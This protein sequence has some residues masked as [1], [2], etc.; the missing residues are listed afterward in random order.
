MQYLALPT[1][2][3]RAEQELNFDWRTRDA[4]LCWYRSRLE[5]L[6]QRDLE[7]K[8]QNQVS[9]AARNLNPKNSKTT[10]VI[11]YVSQKEGYI[12]RDLPKE[13]TAAYRG[14]FASV[15]SA[16]TML[17]RTLPS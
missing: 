17:G 2:R 15:A 7:L 4:L 14:N 5:L 6:G 3:P 13:V 12:P 11:R 8:H 1:A 9:M 10:K 16:P